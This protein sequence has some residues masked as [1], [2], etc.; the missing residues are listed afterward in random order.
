[1]S[2]FRTVVRIPLEPVPAVAKEVPTPNGVLH[3]V[4]PNCAADIIALR[5]GT[6]REGYADAIERL[7][8]P[9]CSQLLEFEEA[10]PEEES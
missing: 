7:M 6:K 9:G 8:C 1:M 10:E 5:P 2:T 4:C 3:V